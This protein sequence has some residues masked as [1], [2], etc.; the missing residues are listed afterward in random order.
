[1]RKLLTGLS[2]LLTLLLIL[3][4]FYGAYWI[5]KT[6]SYSIFYEEMVKSTITEMVKP[7]AMKGE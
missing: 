6:V 3:A 7:E 2:G 4:S 5:A 1:M